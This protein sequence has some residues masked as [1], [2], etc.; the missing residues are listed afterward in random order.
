MNAFELLNINPAFT[1]DLK[2]L[3]Q[4]YFKLQ[5]KIHPDQMGGFNDLSTTINQAY[6]LLK[7]P[8]TRA[9]ELLKI[10]GI[11]YMDQPQNMEL[12]ME[13]ME[14]K[15]NGTII[16]R[17]DLKPIM[18]DFQK[19]IETNQQ[20]DIIKTFQRFNYFYKLV[21]HHASSNI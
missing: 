5:Q 7:N 14:L 1:I 16:E 13:I 17:H 21:Y 8:L 18:D 12:L 6:Q 4:H 10:K 19:A 2:Q 20:T 3:D 9:E 11:D 15:E